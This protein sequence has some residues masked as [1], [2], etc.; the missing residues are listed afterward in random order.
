[1]TNS[2]DEF[3]SGKV[4][5]LFG[6]SYHTKR[7]RSKNPKLNFS[8]AKVPQAREDRE[9]NY[10]SYW[11]PVVLNTS[12]SKDAAW[13]FITYASSSGV[14]DSF[15]DATKRPPAIKSYLLKY[16]E[17]FDLAPFVDQLLTAKTWYRGSNANA[18]EV[19]F[20]KMINKVLYAEVPETALQEAVQTAAS[21]IGKGY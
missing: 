20:E 4:A 15:L 3:A 13:D 12:T 16:E 19:A 7:I 14:V 2:I 6:Y 21:E 1:M 10:A 11:A 8:T 18:A 5:F 9:I 17:D